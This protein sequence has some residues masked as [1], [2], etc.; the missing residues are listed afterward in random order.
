MN[1]LLS[2][3]VVRLKKEKIFWIG[4]VFMALFGSFLAFSAYSDYQIYELKPS[5][6]RTLFAYGPL[7]GI[8]ISTFSGLFLGIEYSDGTIRNK[9]I[10]GHR[11]STVYLSNLLLNIA[12][13]ILM[14]LSFQLALFLL[15]T[16]LLGVEVF[17]VETGFLLFHLA[18]G[19]L[20]T[21]AYCA[22]FT[23][24]SMLIQKRASSSVTAILVSLILLF[25]GAMVSSRLAEPEYYSNYSFTMNT[26][27]VEETNREP[28]PLYLRGTKREIYKFLLDFLPGAQSICLSE[29]GLEHWPP[30]VYSLIITVS[31]S[32][33]G[34]LFFKRKNLN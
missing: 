7:L 3:G 9:L 28:N 14:I 20:L 33:G 25:A 5:L 4:I 34:I 6:G 21:A 23:F 30:L 31:F 17:S 32:C 11:R 2:A 10:A 18:G 13:S 16:L 8:L 29:G 12:A 19:F 15:G 24:I 1:R 27:D 22:V 26:G